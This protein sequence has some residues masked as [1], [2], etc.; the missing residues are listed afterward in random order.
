MQALRYHC[1]QRAC[2]T[3][4]PRALSNTQRR[5][6]NALWQSAAS[7][8]MYSPIHRFVYVHAMRAR[9]VQIYQIQEMSHKSGF[10]SPFRNP[11]DLGYHK[12]FFFLSYFCK[13]AKHSPS[14]R[15]YAKSHFFANRPSQ[16]RYYTTMVQGLQGFNS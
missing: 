10:V 4:S 11:V 15:A 13:I 6:S 9:I 7:K 5:P 1:T 16:L 2:K 8:R 14:I 3:P 12:S